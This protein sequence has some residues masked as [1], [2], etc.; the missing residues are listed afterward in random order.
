MKKTFICNGML[1]KLCKFLRIYGI[2]TQY[3]NKGMVLLLKA[4]KENRIILTKNTKLRNREGVFFIHSSD[5]IDQ[6][7]EVTTHYDL[8]RYFKPL[9]RCLECNSELIP[10]SK[11]KIKDI[12]PYYTYK[13]FDDFAQC[14]ECHKV[15]WQGSHYK[16]MIKKIKKIRREMPYRD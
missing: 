14:P 12:V 11:E 13:N 1:G 9:S 2:D 10:V 15:Y 7:S 16:N 6:I 4:R 3:S 5:P 8:A